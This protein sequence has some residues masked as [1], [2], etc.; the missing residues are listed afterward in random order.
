MNY[1]FAKI[2][3]TISATSDSLPLIK[4]VF[5]VTKLNISV[6]ARQRCQKVSYFAI[7]MTELEK[8]HDEKRTKMLQEMS[9]AW[10]LFTGL[11]H[12]K[13]HLKYFRISLGRDK[14]KWGK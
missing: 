5:F 3:K 1:F 10:M 13:N 8:C 6:L 4:S 11:C 14:N 2:S 7:I 9:T 12:D